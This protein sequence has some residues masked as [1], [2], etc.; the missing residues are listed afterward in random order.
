MGSWKIGRFF[1]IDVYV[2]FLFLLVPLFTFWSNR[3]YGLAEA[4]YDVAVVLTLFFCVLLHEY[5]HALM[6]RC[7]GIGTRDITLTP[8]GGIARLNRMSEH[9]LEEFA[10]AVAGPA[11]NVAIALGLYGGMTLAK[12]PALDAELM[13]FGNYT[14]RFMATLLWLN[15]ILVAFNLLPAFPM[16]GGRVLRALLSMAMDRVRAT[17]IAAGVGSVMTVLFFIAGLVFGSWTL[18]LVAVFIYFVGRQE[19]AMV[20]FQEYQRR[21]QRSGSSA[22]ATFFASADPNSPGFNGYAWDER[23]HAWVE[24]RDG[25]PVGLKP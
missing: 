17:E 9:P 22:S 5:G 6:A 19:L 20:R 15:I 12:L 21:Q 3:Q 1:G 18:P 10:I 4:V 23:N 24:F 8:I 25:R 11:V 2:H 16:D 13:M 7:F 14:L